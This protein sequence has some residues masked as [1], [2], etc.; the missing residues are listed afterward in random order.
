MGDRMTA[1]YTTA[2]FSIS[3]RAGSGNKLQ[4]S[5]GRAADRNGGGDRENPIKAAPASVTGWEVIARSPGANESSNGA[6][7]PSFWSRWTIGR[8]WRA[9]GARRPGRTFAIGRRPIAA[10]AAVDGSIA[11][12]WS[13]NTADAVGETIASSAKARTIG[14]RRTPTLDEL[15][16]LGEFAATQHVVAVRVEPTE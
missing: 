7:A 11:A 9:I 6:L 15:R 10:T 3:T 13:F 4:L 5:T 14:P 8:I 1:P 2:Y 16:K 12:R